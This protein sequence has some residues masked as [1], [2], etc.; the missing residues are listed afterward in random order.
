MVFRSVCFIK[1]TGGSATTAHGVVQ[2][3]ATGDDTLICPWHGF[4]YN[5]TN[6]SLLV[7]PNV[8]LET[9]PVMIRD[10]KV[11]LTI[12]MATLSPYAAEAVEDISEADL[13][14]PSLKENEFLL[15]ALGPGQVMAVELDGETVAVYNVEGKYYATQNDCTHAMGPLSEGEL[16]GYNIVCPWHASCFD[17]RDGSVTCPPAR[18]PV[19][20]Y[21]VIVDGEVGRVVEEE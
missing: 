17:V 1:G 5:V 21:K 2:S 12:P 6:G 20:T 7:D 11:H 16:D 13:T 4:A 14:V 15:S 8:K 18:T 10:G 3:L 9:Y 19:E